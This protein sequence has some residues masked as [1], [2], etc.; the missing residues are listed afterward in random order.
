MRE[1]AD[2]GKKTKGGNSITPTSEKMGLWK[3]GDI[4]KEHDGGV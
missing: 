2:L 4:G 1:D 3:K